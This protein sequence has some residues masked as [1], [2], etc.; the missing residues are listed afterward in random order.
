MTKVTSLDI[1]IGLYHLRWRSIYLI[2]KKVAGNIFKRSKDQGLHLL[3]HKPTFPLI[4]PMHVGIKWLQTKNWQRDPSWKCLFVQSS[5]HFAVDVGFD[6]DVDID[7]GLLL[8]S[9]LMMMPKT[10]L[11]IE[12]KQWFVESSIPDP[13]LCTLFIVCDPFVQFSKF[14]N[15][16][17][18]FSG[19]QLFTSNYLQG[20]HNWPQRT[21]KWNR[22]LHLREAS[23]TCTCACNWALPKWEGDV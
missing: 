22:S 14:S 16:Q 10:K 23:S 6:V 21:L 4:L 17:C 2:S 12:F 13:R 11:L 7:D 8:I 9:V 15:T 19:L 20:L 5:I 3:L 1:H 18:W